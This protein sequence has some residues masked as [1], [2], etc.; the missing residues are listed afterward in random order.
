[1][2]S[3]SHGYYLESTGGPN[4][5]IPQVPKATR[6]NKNIYVLGRA[7]R[8]LKI[9]LPR[10]PS[11]RKRTSNSDPRTNSERALRNPN[12]SPPAQMPTFGARRLR[13]AATPLSDWGVAVVNTNTSAI[14]IQKSS[15]AQLR[16]SPPAAGSSLPTFWA[17]PSD[18]KAGGVPL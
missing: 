12:P 15:P 18:A 1:M 13:D 14:R 11:P 3:N 5:P 17:G 4:A 6:S 7:G 16:W 8:L 9:S 2:K 10:W